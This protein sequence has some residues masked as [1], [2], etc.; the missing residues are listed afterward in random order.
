MRPP[1]GQWQASA[2]IACAVCLVLA[3]S[4]CGGSSNADTQKVAATSISKQ[5]FVAR[6]EE[7]CARGRLRGL[8]YEPVGD[9]ESEREALAS[10]IDAT[11]LPALGEVVDEIYALGAPAGGR[12]RIEDLLNA[13]QQAVDEA[14]EFDEPTL[15]QVEK[16]LAPP[17]ALARKQGLEACVFA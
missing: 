2:P 11:L 17:G 16:L 9:D 12:Q 10:A 15:E 5:E 6:A 8:R 4:G 13:L 1:A 7:I 3:L 14:E